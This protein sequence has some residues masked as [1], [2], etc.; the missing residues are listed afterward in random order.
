M[1]ITAA[2]PQT[3]GCGDIKNFKLV[4]FKE[5]GRNCNDDIALFR[6]EQCKKIYLGGYIELFDNVTS[7][8]S[9]IGILLKRNAGYS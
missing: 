5:Q 4:L 1:R 3:L 7:L 9:T 8:K 2:A 6:F